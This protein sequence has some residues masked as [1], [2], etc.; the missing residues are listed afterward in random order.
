[1]IVDSDLL[2][3]FV[4]RDGVGGGDGRLR[5]VLVCQMIQIINLPGELLS[6]PRQHIDSFSEN[7]ECP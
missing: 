3:V 1:M 6:L 2:P 4:V 7:I 5:Y